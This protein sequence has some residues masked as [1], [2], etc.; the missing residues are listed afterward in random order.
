[1]LARIDEAVAQTPGWQAQPDQGL[2]HWRNTEDGKLIEL[3]FSSS[4]AAPDGGYDLGE[5]LR[6]QP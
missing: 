1:M 5:R 3:S 6:V 4:A 2:H